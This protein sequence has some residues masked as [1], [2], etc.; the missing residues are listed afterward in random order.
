MKKS[1]LAP[2][3]NFRRHQ[4]GHAQGQYAEQARISHRLVLLD[5]KVELAFPLERL[6]LDGATCLEGG[7]V[8]TLV[9]FLKAMEFSGL[10][11]RVSEATG[12]DANED[13]SRPLRSLLT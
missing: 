5:D 8:K 1:R 9:A 7:D 4:R 3:G 13:R 6:C 11:K 2:L 12:I 10:I